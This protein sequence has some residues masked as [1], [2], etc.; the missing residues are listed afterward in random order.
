MCRGTFFECKRTD[1][2]PRV[3]PDRQY[4]LWDQPLLTTAVKLLLEDAKGQ[5]VDLRDRLLVLP[6][7]QTGRRF[8]E[9]LALEMGQRGGALFP[10]HDH[11][12]STS[13]ATNRRRGTGVRLFVAMNS[14]PVLNSEPP[15][16]NTRRQ[17][18]LP[19]RFHQ[20]LT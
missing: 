15:Y 18:R 16:Q 10:P 14:F 12:P 6:T 3:I 9:A 19:Q 1:T 11:H 7:R 8:R 13:G 20:Q 4:K 2:S 17:P 5:A